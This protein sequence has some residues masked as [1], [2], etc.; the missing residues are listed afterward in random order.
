MHLIS[1]YWVSLTYCS[2]RV[3]SCRVD[4]Y[5]ILRRPTA[6]HFYW[7]LCGIHARTASRGLEESDDPV[8]LQ[9]HV[10]VVEAWARRQAG[11]RHDVAALHTTKM[12]VC[13]S[14]IV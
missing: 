4:M 5:R 3:V 2:C 14:V 7:T 10:D 1:N 6:P 8:V 12:Q 11:N 13:D 9:V